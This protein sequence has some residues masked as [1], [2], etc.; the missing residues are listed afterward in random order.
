MALATTDI[1][2]RLSTTA[3]AAGN[4]TAQ[5]APTSSLGKYI[6][7]TDLVDATVENLFA[8]VSVVDA[9]TGKEYYLCLFAYNAH[10]SQSWQNAVVWL[11]SQLAGGG[12]AYVGVDPT[13]ASAVGSASAQAVQIANINTAPAGVTFANPTT[14]ETALSLGTVPAGYCKAFWFKLVVAADAL[15]QNLDNALYE[16][17]GLS[18]P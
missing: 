14:L 17:V 16:L 7:T 13:A 5:G 2:H 8:N 1:K 4:S 9:G 15:A 18:D 12:D 11:Q 6:S 10:G 3:G